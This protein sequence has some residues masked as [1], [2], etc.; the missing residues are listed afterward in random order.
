MCG[1]DMSLRLTP[2]RPTNRSDQAESGDDPKDCQ[3]HIASNRSVHL[4]ESQI[5]TPLHLAKLLA[6]PTRPAESPRGEVDK[7]EILEIFGLE[8]AALLTHFV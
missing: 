5:V 2:M 7:D 8:E 3:V 6:T 1:L 4:A